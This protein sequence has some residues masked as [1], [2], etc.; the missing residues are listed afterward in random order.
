MLTDPAGAASRRSTVPLSW[1]CDPRAVLGEVAAAVQGTPSRRMLILG[2][3]GTNGKTTTTYL[4]DAGLR[5][6]GHRTG[7]VGTVETRVGD[8]VVP[9]VRTTPEAPDLQR[10]LARMVRDGCTA[11]SMEVS[12]HALALGRVDG[13]TFD[14]ALFTNLSQD[15]LDFH[16]TIEAYFAAKARAV[17]P[18]VARGTVWS[19]STTAWGRRLAAEATVPVTTLSAAGAPADWQVP[20]RRTDRRAGPTWRRA[21]GPAARTCRCPWRSPGRSTCPTRWLPW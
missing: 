7:L 3:T 5:A 10:L 1:S 21:A 20:R 9:S 2:V 13:T 19:T 11:V 15:H 6:A 12:S 14:V 4:L 16:P 8:T 18:R 17:H